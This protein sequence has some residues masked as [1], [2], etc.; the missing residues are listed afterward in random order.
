MTNSF[1]NSKHKLAFVTCHS[2]KGQNLSQVVFILV[3]RP[4]DGI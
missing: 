4:N 1:L 3:V 2:N